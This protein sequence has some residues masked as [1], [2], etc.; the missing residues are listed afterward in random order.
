MLARVVGEEIVSCH[1]IAYFLA[2]VNVK[3]F[4]LLE[5]GNKSYQR[6]PYILL[7]EATLKELVIIKQ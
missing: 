4:S 5:K 6:M 7:L 3:A 1:F 2:F